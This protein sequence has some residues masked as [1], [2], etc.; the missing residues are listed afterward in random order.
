MEDYECE[1]PRQQDDQ[2]GNSNDPRC[3]PIQPLG[4]G[5]QGCY[6]RR[7]LGSLRGLLGQEV[8]EIRIF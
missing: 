1:Y 6:G 2:E 7:T 4:W 8:F 3:F 5:N